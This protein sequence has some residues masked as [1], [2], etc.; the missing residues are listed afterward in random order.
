MHFKNFC[1]EC[2]L[3][4]GIN[5]FTTHRNCSNKIPGCIE[6]RSDLCMECS[7][8]YNLVNQT[9]IFDSDRA[10]QHCKKYTLK[11][12]NCYRCVKDYRLDINGDNCFNTIENCRIYLNKDT[13]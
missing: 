9:C 8:V 7:S 1:D 12:G 3:N 6:Y 4:Y 10:I 5:D 2:D 13:C 11:T